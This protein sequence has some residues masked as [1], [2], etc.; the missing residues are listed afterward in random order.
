LVWSRVDDVEHQ[1]AGAEALPD[2]GD[3][4]LDRRFHDRLP[5]RPELRLGSP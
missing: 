1:E 2:H 5:L 3:R 4:A